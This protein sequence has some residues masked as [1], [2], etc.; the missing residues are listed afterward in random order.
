MLAL[1]DTQENLWWGALAIG[2][3]N[4]VFAPGE[5]MAAAQKTA[6]L[7]ATKGPVAVGTA[8]H[9]IASGLDVSLA[10]GN[11]LEIAAFSQCFTTQDA[12]EGMGAFLEKR[13][14]SFQG[15]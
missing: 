14:A 15:E 6:A 4:A 2:L 5:L 13:E 9:V 1:T 3:V 7:I 10:A 12:S 8:K 11:E